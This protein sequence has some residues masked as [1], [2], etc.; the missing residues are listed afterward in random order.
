V[1]NQKTDG[2]FACVN[3]AKKN[4]LPSAILEDPTGLSGKRLAASN[5]DNYRRFARAIYLDQ[6]NSSA[7]I[8]RNSLGIEKG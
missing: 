7:G 1:P 8:A 6:W 5:A 4:A 3:L 2:F